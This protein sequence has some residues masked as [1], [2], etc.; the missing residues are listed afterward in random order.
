M[1]K[2]TIIGHAEKKVNYD[3]AV[4]DLSFFSTDKNASKAMQEVK[5]QTED[6]LKH[7]KDKNVDISQINFDKDSISSSYRNENEMTATREILMRIPYN[8]DFINYI[9]KL[10]RDNNYDV[11]YD[12]DFELSDENSI[13]KELLKE[14][15]ANAREKADAIAESMGQKVVALKSASA[16]QSRFMDQFLGCL[17]FCDEEECFE[18]EEDNSLSGEL[19]APLSKESESIETTWILEDKVE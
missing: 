5:R 16:G 1:G 3:I 18:G 13:H 2:I 19:Q 7:L 9:S 11:R 17:D 4:L 15:M 14:A 8:M 6:F 10:I 12:M